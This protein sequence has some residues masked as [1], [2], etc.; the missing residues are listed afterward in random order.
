MW[1]GPCRSTATARTLVEDNFVLAP[2]EQAKHPYR[3]LYEVDWKSLHQDDG[4]DDLAKARKQAQELEVL[5]SHAKN[6]LPRHST[7][8]DRNHLHEMWAK[9]Q[10]ESAGSR[11]VDF[12]Q[13]LRPVDFVIMLESLRPE[14]GESNMMLQLSVPFGQAVAGDCTQ[15]CCVEPYKY[16][17]DAAEE[18]RCYWFPWVHNNLCGL[19]KR[20]KYP[21]TAYHLELTAAMQVYPENGSARDQ[22]IVLKALLSTQGEGVYATPLGLAISSK[23]WSKM[24]V[25]NNF[26]CAYHLVV[27]M[28]LM[29]F[30][31]QAFYRVLP[32]AW[33]MRAYI[34]FSLAEILYRTA[35]VIGACVLYGHGACWL[36]LQKA[37]GGF[38]ALAYTTTHWICLAISASMVW[39]LRQ[40]QYE[41]PCKHDNG[42]WFKAHNCQFMLLVMARCSTFL[43]R[44]L[45]W[46]PLGEASLPAINAVRAKKTRWYTAFLVIFWL[47]AAAAFYVEPINLDTETAH[48]CK[49][50]GTWP[51][52]EEMCNFFAYLDK[53]F[54][55]DFM[56]Q[57]D[58][59]ELENVGKKIHA[60][61]DK[62]GTL[63]GLIHDSHWSKYHIATELWQI[64]SGFVINILLLNVFISI[65]STEYDQT[66]KVAVA[67]LMHYRSCFAFRDLLT[68]VAWEHFYTAEPGTFAELNHFEQHLIYIKSDYY[69]EM[70]P[71]EEELDR[72]RMENRQLREELEKIKGGRSFFQ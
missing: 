63:E 46:E 18:C 50:S 60:S 66:C 49:K 11:L 47:L 16:S 71:K 51:L 40:L 43:M 15:P 3:H 61:V 23:V 5:H 62:G 57:F 54:N 68:R 52:A 37:F 26:A 31:H 4:E 24:R 34:V 48:V 36:G 6:S 8:L 72:L 25:Q 44:L 56:G 20:M 2:Q 29:W 38:W 14:C 28:L 1:T 69:N 7:R 64:G 9:L 19:D 39:S 17:E 53:V 30:G 70:H 21:R 65:V 12:W 58:L 13:Q 32:G 22:A 10:A 55:V 42:C 27:L 35:E 33:L 59:D 41:A 45:C 67:N